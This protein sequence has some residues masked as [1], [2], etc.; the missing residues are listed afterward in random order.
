MHVTSFFKRSAKQKHP[1]IIM[2]TT[3]DSDAMHGIEGSTRKTQNQNLI[4]MERIN[5]EFCAMLVRPAVKATTAKSPPT[6]INGEFELGVH[7]ADQ[8]IDLLHSCHLF[9]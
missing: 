4:S 8:N 7:G 6:N 1:C 9:V 2:S 5:S 3:G